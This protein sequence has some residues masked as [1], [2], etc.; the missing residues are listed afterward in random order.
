MA[1]EQEILLKK[2]IFK[3][4]KLGRSLIYLANYKKFF[5][6]AKKLS[7]KDPWITAVGPKFKT[8]CIIKK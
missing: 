2:K 1:T 4:A 5:Y 8:K 6:L 3:S 7:K